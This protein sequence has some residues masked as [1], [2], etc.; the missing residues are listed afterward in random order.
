[1]ATKKRKLYAGSPEQQDSLPDTMPQEYR[2][3]RESE[4]MV[5]DCFYK[6]C[7]NLSGHGLSIAE[8]QTAVVEVANG[9]FGIHWKMAC[10]SEN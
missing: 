4:R 5:K 6:T 2:H 9:M 3:V 10:W 1:M 8:S 7:A